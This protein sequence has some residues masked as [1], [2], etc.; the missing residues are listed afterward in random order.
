M[1]P[2]TMTM[3]PWGPVEKSE[4]IA[5]GVLLVSTAEH[6]G[7]HLVPE[8]A[9]AIPRKIGES[10]LHG[11]GWPDTDAEM[12]IALTLLIDAGKIP[13]SVADRFTKPRDAAAAGNAVA[14]LAL[15]AVQA[16]ALH[17]YPWAIRP[18]LGILAKAKA[19]ARPGDAADDQA[20]GGAIPMKPRIGDDMAAALLTLREYA[21]T[22]ADDP[23]KTTDNGVYFIVEDD[24]Q[25][26]KFGVK[27]AAELLVR[28]EY[29][30][31][32]ESGD[33]ATP[34]PDAKAE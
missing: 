27:L 17:R 23:D 24:W 15:R 19:N 12:P 10:F 20:G 34:A 4:E 32:P 29:V 22:F 18:L 3:C 21:L 9:K 14:A 5:D 7:L 28:H 26:V 13:A 8:S 1:Q 33:A 31:D 30:A 2:P 11:P 25:A 16:A 6:G